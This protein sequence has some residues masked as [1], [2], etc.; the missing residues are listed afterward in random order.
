MNRQTI[1]YI[2]KAIDKMSPTFRSMEKSFK[3]AIRRM[4]VSSKKFLRDLKKDF[5]GTMKDLGKG[6]GKIGRTLTAKLTAPLLVAG[7]AMVKYAIDTEETLNKVDVVFGESAKHVREWAKTSLTSMGLA[8]QSAMD[9]AALYGDM[10]TSM[11]IPQA[12]AA[13]MS[14]SLTQLSA[15]LASFKNVSA[16]RAMNALKGVYTG[17]GEALKNLGIVMTQTNVQN[18]ALSKGIRKKMKDMSQAELVE[19]RYQYVMAKTKSAQGDFIRTGGGAANQ[20]RIFK[21][22]LK[23]LAATFGE[24]I[25]PYFTKAVKSLNKFIT[26]LSKLSPT[27]KKIILV[28]GLLLAVLGPLLMMFGMIATAVAAI[29]WPVLLVVAAVTAFIAILV[30]LY[31]NLDKIKNFFTNTRLGKLIKAAFDISPLGLIIKAMEKVL[32]LGT[33]V[34]EKI[35]GG[36]FGKFL[37]RAKDNFVADAKRFGNYLV[38]DINPVV[39]GNKPLDNSKNQGRID[40]SIVIE[41]KSENKV[42]GAF[43]TSGTAE[44]YGTLMKHATGGAY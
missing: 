24:H 36:E 20:T 8:S 17:E 4:K 11:D 41:N 31:S 21:E 37:G 7:G 30:A 33:K 16:D 23:Q 6:L 2:F 35:T 28:V 9:A 29:S 44:G 34:K 1:S 22:S 40:G 26:W 5:S 42:S 18:F 19:L 13:E 15:D 3:Y 10:G 32:E 14:M 12:K 43:K 25:L 38:G 27:V 39:E